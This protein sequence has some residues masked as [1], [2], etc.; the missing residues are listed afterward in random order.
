MKKKAVFTLQNLH[1]DYQKCGLTT[2]ESKTVFSSTNSLSKIEL[3]EFEFEVIDNFKYLGSIVQANGFSDRQLDK[4]I[5][6]EKKGGY[7]YA[8]LNSLE[9]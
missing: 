5:V 6:E 1:E 9:H 7:W 2:N 4:R 3:E 8:E